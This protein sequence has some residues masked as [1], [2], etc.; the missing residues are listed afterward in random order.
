MINQTNLIAAAASKFRTYKVCIMHNKL[1]FTADALRDYINLHW[2]MSLTS[3]EVNTAWNNSKKIARLTSFDCLWAYIS[4]EAAKPKLRANALCQGYQLD[5]TKIPIRLLR[6]FVDAASYANVF[7]LTSVLPNNDF[8]IYYRSNI[9]LCNFFYNH[10]LNVDD[11]AEQL[12]FNISEFINTVLKNSVQNAINPS[13]QEYHI[14][15]ASM[16]DFTFNYL[17]IIKKSI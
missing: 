9:D 15:Q 5:Y 16:K 4:T 11:A 12:D 3:D 14:S 10:V 1:F 13:W 8:V 2:N 7:A 17:Q 6:Y